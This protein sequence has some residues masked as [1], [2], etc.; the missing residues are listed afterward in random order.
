[1]DLYIDK[2][3]TKDLIFINGDCPVTSDYVESVGQRIFVMLRT[4]E[5]EWFLN[6]TTGVPYYNIL[7]TKISQQSIDSIIQ[8]KILEEPG[9]SE[10]VS[11]YSSL[12]G[13]RVY[14]ATFRVRAVSGGL[15]DQ[16][17]DIG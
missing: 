9:V 12:E 3:E 2:D 6:T 4:F 1:M 11:Y 15:I 17:F 13:D 14:R 7:G 5:A 16:S 10:I 8:R